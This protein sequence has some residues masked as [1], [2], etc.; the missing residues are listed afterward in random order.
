MSINARFPIEI[1]WRHQLIA[2]H[3]HK[4]AFNILARWIDVH[5]NQ[6]LWLMA[7]LSRPIVVTIEYNKPRVC[8][9]GLCAPSRSLRTWPRCSCLL[10]G[11]SKAGLHIDMFSYWKSC[12]IDRTSYMLYS[13]AILLKTVDCDRVLNLVTRQEYWNVVNVRQ[14]LVLLLVL[15]TLYDVCGCQPYR[16]S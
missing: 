6:N 7:C 3:R 5:K 12:R 8:A 11:L 13:I 16:L 4:P 15:R 2:S 14:L 10:P 1:I 9:D